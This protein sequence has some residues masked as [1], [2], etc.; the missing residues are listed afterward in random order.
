MSI[1][2][3]I[4]NKNG[5]VVKNEKVTY[6]TVITGFETLESS[7]DQLSMSA[8]ISSSF[9][10]LSRALRL[11]V[12]GKVGLKYLTTSTVLV[13]ALSGWLMYFA[14]GAIDYEL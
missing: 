2:K 7:S 5:I 4:E 1:T 10:I 6:F 9:S 14:L 8:G 13:V 12:G 3:W 11:G